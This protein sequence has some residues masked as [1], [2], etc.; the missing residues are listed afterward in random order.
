M[1][2]SEQQAGHADGERWTPSSADMLVGQES[3]VAYLGGVAL[4]QDPSGELAQG[5]L[6]PAAYSEGDA[7]LV[8][9]HAE[10]IMHRSLRNVLL[11]AS[12]ESQRNLTAAEHNFALILPHI[13]RIVRAT[14]RERKMQLDLMNPAFRILPPMPLTNPQIYGHFCHGRKTHLRT[15]HLI[16]PYF[17]APELQHILANRT[18]SNPRPPEQASDEVM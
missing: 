16:S 13:Q 5:L 12:P 10:D 7:E 18:L 2:S 9:Q 3:Y 8:V 14:C 6:G 17:A 11:S 4:L 15:T 1:S